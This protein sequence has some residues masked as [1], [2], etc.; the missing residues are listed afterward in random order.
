MREIS[1]IILIFRKLGL[2]GPIQEKIKL[3]LFYQYFI[4]EGYK[5]QSEVYKGCHDISMM[6]FDLENIAILN[7]KGF[8]YRCVIWNTS[9]GDAINRLN[10][11]K[12]ND[13][14]S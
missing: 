8:D 4:E 11:C 10:K 5:Y 3:P 7:I 6:A 2:V 14:G 9:K 13:K 1:I 12:L